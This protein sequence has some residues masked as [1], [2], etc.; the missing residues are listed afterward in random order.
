MVSTIFFVRRNF[1]IDCHLP[2]YFNFF[3]FFFNQFSNFLRISIRWSYFLFIYIFFFRILILPFL[4]HIIYL[5]YNFS[6]YRTS[7]SSVVNSL[8]PLEGKKK[9][10][11]YYCAIA[12][13][14]PLPLTISSS[15]YLFLSLPLPLT[16]SSSS[17]HYLFSPIHRVCTSTCSVFCGYSLRWCGRTDVRCSSTH[18]SRPIPAVS[19]SSISRYIRSFY[20]FPVS[21]SISVPFI[22]SS[23]PVDWCY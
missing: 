19:T 23:I 10:N 17:S 6:I 12:L 14:I 1:Y 15:H 4:F 8:T 20:S 11:I 18:R 21:Q 2:P 7:Y 9:R 22:S 3:F 5:F 16:I 13:H